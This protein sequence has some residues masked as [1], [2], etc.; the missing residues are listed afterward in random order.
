MLDSCDKGKS[1]APS[2]DQAYQILNKHGY[3]EISV[4]DDGIGI[5]EENLS[6]IFD[7]FYQITNPLSRNFESA[8]IGLALSKE[9]VDLHSG[10]IDVE[11]EHE[12]GTTFFIRLPLGCDHFLLSEILDESDREKSSVA[13]DSDSD[14]N[15][16]TEKLTLEETEKIK[17]KDN[18]IVLIVDDN[19]DI[20]KYVADHLSNEYRILIAKD[21]KEGLDIAISQIPDLIVSDIYM[22]LM[23]GIDLCT[24][25]KTDEL[26]SHIP[27]ILLTVRASGDSKVEGLETGADDYITRPFEIRELKVRI[28]NLIEQRRE[29]KKKF[30]REHGLKPSEITS[31][32]V[33]E[34]Y[35]KKALSIVESNISESSFGVKKF[36]KQML[37]SR[38]QL[39]RKIRALTGQT[40]AEFIRL[41]RLN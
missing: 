32:S 29:L 1:K 7:R 25:I 14:D 3:I 36:A 18:P 9:L 38:A 13:I 40:P 10:T 30:N 5:R 19:S 24:K 39:F 22:S 20:R 34:H 33:D 37:I 15:N 23:N 26:T 28:S 21:G 41:I 27:V 16:T 17:P 11:S 2:N 4:K 31:N 8:G 35:L 12:Q 6:R